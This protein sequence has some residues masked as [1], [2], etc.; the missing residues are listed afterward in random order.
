MRGR[1]DITFWTDPPNTGN[2]RG[3]GP[4]ERNLRKKIKERS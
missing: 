3:Q 2:L 1:R 4:E